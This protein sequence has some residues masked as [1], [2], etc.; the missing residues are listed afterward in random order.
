[1][2]DISF[3]PEMPQQSEARSKISIEILDAEACSVTTVADARAALVMSLKTTTQ[4]RYSLPSLQR[5][6]SVY[7]KFAPPVNDSMA[8]DLDKGADFLPLMC[9]SDA[10]GI[11]LLAYAREFS[12]GLHVAMEDDYPFT[13]EGSDPRFT[14]CQCFVAPELLDGLVVPDMWTPACRVLDIG[15]RDIFGVSLQD[16]RET[17]LYN[18]S[19]PSPNYHNIA[20]AWQLVIRQISYVM[21]NMDEPSIAAFLCAGRANSLALLLGLNVSASYASMSEKISYNSTSREVTVGPIGGGNSIE[22]EIFESL[23]FLV[24]ADK[25]EEAWSSLL[26]TI[27]K[28][29]SAL[30]G[31]AKTTPDNKITY[32]VKKDDLLPDQIGDDDFT[33]KSA[34][35]SGISTDYPTWTGGIVKPVYLEPV[36][37]TGPVGAVDPDLG[38]EDSVASDDPNGIIDG[39]FD[40]IVEEL[41]DPE[42]DEWKMTLRALPR[43][44]GDV[45][46]DCYDSEGVNPGSTALILAAL[47]A[48]ISAVTPDLLY[49]A[50]GSELPAEE[51]KISSTYTLKLPRVTG[52]YQSKIKSLSISKRKIVL[53]SVLDSLIA[54]GVTEDDCTGFVEHKGKTYP[55]LYVL[56]STD[57]SLSRPVRLFNSAEPSEDYDK[58]VD[59]L[60]PVMQDIVSYPYAV[61]ANGFTPYAGWYCLRGSDVQGKVNNHETILELGS[62]DV[63]LSNVGSYNVAGL[64]RT[65]H[66]EFKHC[67]DALVALTKA[68][69]EMGDESDSNKNYLGV[70]LAVVGLGLVGALAAFLSK[71]TKTKDQDKQFAADEQIARTELMR[72]QAAQI[73][74]Q[75]PGAPVKTSLINL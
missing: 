71:D 36:G 65:C 11:A 26:R 10:F 31:Q 18:G 63:A 23:A 57:A 73:N 33:V 6:S 37:P 34:G 60:V 20:G 28:D 54:G 75:L 25:Q 8:P 53:N 42:S 49:A 74:N 67:I 70:V 1:M 27:V 48:E 43:T 44:S 14:L 55:F 52:S 61:G 13:R 7:G 2:A 21:R 22:A 17:A 72:A 47:E 29:V 12:R 3:S 51:R 62:Y 39:G 58:L 66:T 30:G 38:D 46:S 56:N 5:T 16:V 64:D 19:N 68:A 40:E 32:Q 69:D 24:G 41:R 9:T 4:P 15:L 50:L 35:G 45:L 59:D